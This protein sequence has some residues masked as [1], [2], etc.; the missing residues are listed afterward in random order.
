MGIELAVF[1]EIADT[2]I[3][4]KLHHCYEDKFEA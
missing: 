1:G 4:R 2:V 3:R